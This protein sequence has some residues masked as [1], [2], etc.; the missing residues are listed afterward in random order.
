M[1]KFDVLQVKL[2]QK[3]ISVLRQN[4]KYVQNAVF[5]KPAGS[6]S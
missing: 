3:Q 1:P 2:I 4:M 6:A 5:G